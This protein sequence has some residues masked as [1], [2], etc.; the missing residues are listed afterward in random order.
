MNIRKQVQNNPWFITGD[1]NDLLCS[2]DKEGGPTRAE[3]SF[4]DMRTFYAENDLYDLQYS[5]DPLSWRGQRGI[6]YVRCRLDRAAANSKWAEIYPTA[7]SM[8]M[9]YEG[10]DHRPLL[11]V[12]E[13]G[14]KKGKGLFRYDRRLKDNPEATQVIVDAWKEEANKPIIHR[15]ARVRSAIS[16]WH[17]NRH[18]N[19]RD[20]I[21]EKKIELEE[22]LSS[23]ANDL[24]LIRKI[25]EELKKAYAD[26]EAYWKQRSR[27]LWL[28][29]GDRN[30]GYFHADT[31]NRKRANSFSVIE[32]AEGNMV[33]KEGQISTVII[34]YFKDLFTSAG[35]DDLDIVERA[36]TP[37]ITAEDNELLVSIPS[38]TEI[39]DAIFSVHADKAPGPD[40]F[41]ASFFHSNWDAIGV[42]IVLEV[43][44]FFET[45]FL[46]E[47]INE[48]F[49]RL[50]PKIQNPKAVS[51][52][53]P[54]A[55]CNVYYKIFSKILTKRMQPL[56][57]QVISENQSAFVLG[58][59]F[60]ITSLLHMKSST[61]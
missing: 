28:R 29:L 15:I 57:A 33:Y 7:R 21:V 6:H 14:K 44:Q 52:Y 3:G 46:P 18:L 60:R 32:D 45:G 20:K 24:V 36:L 41:S 50:I 12:F 34:N 27:L 9:A 47:K 38:A 19:S 49:V 17:K 26:E 59:R 61:T 40:G 39:K 5:G 31:K 55:L 16:I 43:Q 8:Y 42:D 48:T 23:T 53:R 1:F 58:E 37:K 56:L 10:S 4:S 25:S 54:I 11:S 13:P 35:R 2:E 22:A 30:S 51:D